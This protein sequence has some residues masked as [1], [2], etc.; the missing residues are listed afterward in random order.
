MPEKIE[1]VWIPRDHNGLKKMQLMTFWMMTQ[2]FEKKNKSFT[3]SEYFNHKTDFS[4]TK[5]TDR[6]ITRTKKF[7]STSSV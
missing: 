1:I 6:K 2:A 7:L 5:S 4:H 3:V